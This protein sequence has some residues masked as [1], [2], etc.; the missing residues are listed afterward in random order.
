MRQKNAGPSH[1]RQESQVKTS[2]QKESFDG[3]QRQGFGHAL[4]TSKKL[5]YDGFE[6]LF[7]GFRR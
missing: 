6:P 7:E 4:K 1:P 3:P 2:R 5:A